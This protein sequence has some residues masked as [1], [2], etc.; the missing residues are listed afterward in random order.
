MLVITDIT[1]KNTHIEVRL[2]TGDLLFLPFSAIER[3]ALKTGMSIDPTQYGFLRDESNRHLC[4]QKALDYLSIRNRTA[5]ETERFLAKK[6]FDHDIIGGVIRDLHSAGYIDDYRFAVGYIRG[7][8][9]RKV[10]GDNLLRRDLMQKGVES[11]TIRKAISEAA[12]DAISE[13]AVFREA[14]KKLSRIGNKPNRE[15]KVIFFLRQRGF[16]DDMIR[17]VIA[18]LKREHALD[19]IPDPQE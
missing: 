16:G 18:R 17:A 4:A 19:D 13:E 15:A 1:Q 14:Q 11:R 3:I 9:G 2:D 8:R 5:Q 6:G 12:D 7:K 10:V